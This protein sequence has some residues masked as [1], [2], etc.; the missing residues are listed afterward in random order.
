MR[1]LT[2][3][4]FNKDILKEMRA[5]ADNSFK[6]IG[7][8]DDA[9]V[10]A[11]SVV[12]VN[13]VA[14]LGCTMAFGLPFLA[15]PI[16]AIYGSAKRDQAEAALYEAQT[17]V[18]KANNHL[19]KAKTA[20]AL[21]KAIEKRSNQINDVLIGLNRYFEPAIAQ[22]RNITNLY[23]YSY[24]NYPV[25]YNDKLKVLGQV[26]TLAGNALIYYQKQKADAAQRSDE[27][28]SEESKRMKALTQRIKLIRENDGT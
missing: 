2:A 25:E 26:L 1:E 28:L 18:D 6:L 24:R 23:G 4:G 15:A 13:T 21:F 27:N 20:C 16:M 22:L 17:N 19:E 3:D 11:T 12:A 7:S 8:P 5:M 9:K 14:T 10:S